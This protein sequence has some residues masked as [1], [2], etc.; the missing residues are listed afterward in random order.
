MVG[1]RD[2]GKSELRVVFVVA[3]RGAY[4]QAAPRAGKHVTLICP[5][6]L[7]DTQM[8]IITIVANPPMTDSSAMF[9]NAETSLGTG[10]TAASRASIF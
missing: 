4:E 8:P 5:I 6:A 3:G 2:H 1:V 9:P 10:H 7:H